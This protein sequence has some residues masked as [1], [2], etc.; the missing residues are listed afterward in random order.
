MHL[1]L[2]NAILL[3]LSAGVQSSAAPTDAQQIERAVLDY[4][5][6]FYLSKPELLER[7]VH[8]SLAKLGFTRSEPQAEYELA[9]MSRA[10]LVEL[11]QRLKGYF[12]ADAPKDVVVTGHLDK[13]AAA[14]LT[15]AWGIDFLQLAK[16]E[17]RWQIVHVLWQT[18][19]PALAPE[20]AE[21]DRQ[22]IE[23]AVRTY[24]ESAYE[25]KPEKVDR[26][27]HPDLVKLGFTKRAG[28]ADWT[29]H[30][31]SFGQL[32]D[33]VA[34]WNADGAIPASAPKDVVVLGRLDKIAQ[35]KVTAHWGVDFFHLAKEQGQ[36]KIRQ[37]LWQSHPLGST[38]R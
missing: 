28:D 12:P 13:T 34:T 8:P 21:A 30:A 14:K 36:W 7:S 31:L 20:A 19:A 4:A 17:G 27:V 11:A 2:A 5:E 22:A 26:A 6:A 25:V 16:L 38:S 23:A 15:A 24:V 37:V 29:R 1:S 18:A 32:R 35:A 33:L 3:T 10:E 9:P